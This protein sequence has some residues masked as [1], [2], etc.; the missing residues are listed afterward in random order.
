MVVNG[1]WIIV[2]IEKNI[3]SVRADAS[4]KL[5]DGSHIRE[6]IEH[7]MLIMLI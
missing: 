2:E 4:F 7:E 6:N 3:V 1:H 5:C